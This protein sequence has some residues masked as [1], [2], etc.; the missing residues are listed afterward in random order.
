MKFYVEKGVIPV[1]GSKFEFNVEDSNPGEVIRCYVDDA[2]FKGWTGGVNKI[3]SFQ[4]YFKS[5]RRYESVK[6]YINLRNSLTECEFMLF[7]A[8]SSEE[9]DPLVLKEVEFN[10]QCKLLKTYNLY[11][12]IGSFP[13]SITYNFIEAWMTG[14]PVITF[15]NKIGGAAYKDRPSLYE[16]PDLIQLGVNGIYSDDLTSLKYYIKEVLK[17]KNLANTLSSNGRKR[18]IELFGKEKIKQHWKALIEER[19]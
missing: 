18:A 4:N 11:F 14:I 2:I 9:Q 5:R 13:A 17:D 3:L 12:S 19:I 16:V 6:Q 10:E 15:G 8:Q 7:G 1:R